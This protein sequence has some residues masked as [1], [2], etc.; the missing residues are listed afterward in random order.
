[1]SY[2]EHFEKIKYN[3]IDT[4]NIMNSVLARYHPF[5]N[6]SLYYLY[7]LLDGEKAEDV[8]YNAY[9]TTEYWW[10]LLAIN[11]IVD[12]YHDWMMG[13]QE[14]E[15]FMEGKYGDDLYGVHHFIDVD[16]DGRTED[17]YSSAKWQELI[18]NDLELPVHIQPISN[19]DYE[20]RENEKNRN[21][22]VISIEYI[23]NVQRDFEELMN[24]R[25]II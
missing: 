8:S 19:R 11:N 18:D 10:I 1:M 9:K 6:S 15:A 5:K 14:L 22:K 21:V 2:F 3:G 12:P 24:N 4:V 13:S 16:N 23:D 25:K 20:I 7:T 17:G